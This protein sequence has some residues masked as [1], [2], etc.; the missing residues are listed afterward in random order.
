MTKEEEFDKLLVP[1]LIEDESKTVILL[2][3]SKEKALEWL[4]VLGASGIDYGLLKQE[5]RWRIQVSLE[6]RKRAMDQ[7]HEYEREC[8][9]WPPKI[10]FR[11][12]IEEEI[13]GPSLYAG[14]CLLL[15]FLFTGPYNSKIV[16]FQQGQGSSEKILSGELWRVVTALTLHSDFAHV[17][18]NVICCIFL[19]GGVCQYI[20]S[21]T[22]WLLILLGGAGANIISSLL[23]R[24]TYQYVGAST[25]VFAAIGILAAL[26]SI[27]LYRNFE[28]NSFRLFLPLISLFAILSVLGTGPKADILG[29]FMGAISGLFLG[30]L[31]S[32]L[33]SYRAQTRFQLGGLLLVIITILSS[34]VFA[35][36]NMNFR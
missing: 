18:G 31:F 33:T 1:H 21:G 24:S 29:H 15:F 3:F 16:W 8:R 2:P 36:K 23:H 9:Y 10:D 22:G 32:F 27:R 17:T 30:F 6:N 34:W 4:A 25:G 12:R 7:L 35:L 13:N 19:C 5:G 28:N 20:G 26:Q 11:D 14:I